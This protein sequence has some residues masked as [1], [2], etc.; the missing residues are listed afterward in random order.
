MKFYKGE[1]VS[2]IGDTSNSSDPCIIGKTYKVSEDC[3]MYWVSLEGKK[4]HYNSQKFKL[5]NRRKPK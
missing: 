4:G 5:T 1:K 3:V 2:C